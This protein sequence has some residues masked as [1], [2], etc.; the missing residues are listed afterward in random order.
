MSTIGAE[1]LIFYSDKDNNIY[2]GGFNVNS[3]IMKQ[4]FSP[5][6]T[7]NN[8]LQTGGTTNKVSDLF[9][10]L[11]VPNWTLTYPFKKGGSTNKMNE[12]TKNDIEEDEDFISEDIH[13]KL[14]SMVKVHDNKGS[15]KKTKRILK[16]SNKKTKNNRKKK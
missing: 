3:L 7:L 2:S 10:H 5:I 1:D 8:N 13:E 11:V 4:G 16:L 14:L 9:D 15:N 12:D 6:I